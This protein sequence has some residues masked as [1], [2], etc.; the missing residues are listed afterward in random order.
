MTWTKASAIA[1]ILSSVAILVTLAY[2][3][4][5]IRQNAQATQAET[6]QAILAADQEFLHILL[7]DPTLVVL[8]HQQE[9]DDKERVRLSMQLLTILRMREMNWIQHQNG[10][11]DDTTWRA[12]LG[13]LVAVLS[14]PQS[15]VWWENYGVERVFDPRFVSLVDDL[16]T[17][18]P[19]FDA[20]PH[21]N[22]FD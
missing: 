16:L 6:R 15:R 11:I 17:D 13:S 4:I 9:L 19:V 1:E 21:I 18:K 20:S 3:A 14:A 7:Q 2:L 8:R 22:A 12:Y 5:E 10:T